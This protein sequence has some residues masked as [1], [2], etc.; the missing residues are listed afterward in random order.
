MCLLMFSF[1]SPV[2]ANVINLYWTKKIN[3]RQ[4]LHPRK[5]IYAAFPGPIIKTVGHAVADRLRFQCMRLKLHIGMTRV[6]VR[7]DQSNKGK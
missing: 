7:H 4:Y 3:A 2:L 6:G 5:S 1:R